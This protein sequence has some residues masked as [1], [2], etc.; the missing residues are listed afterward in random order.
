M[1]LSRKE[2][3]ESIKFPDATTAPGPSTRAGDFAEILVAD[4]LEFIEEY[5][6]PSRTTRYSNKIK[7][8]ESSKGNDVIALRLVDFPN[9]NLKD[10]L[11]IFEAK[12]K[13]TGRTATERLQDA[14]DGSV[15]D[16]L[17]LAE[18]L[19][20]MKQRFIDCG[21]MDEAKMIDRF[22]KEA[23]RPDSV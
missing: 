11:A 14:I 4:F 10:E 9:V 16:K 18:S 19:N 13:F 5:H 6:V 21:S 7:R 3:L 2:Y 8:N 1:G 12:A 20:A 22:Q 23:V 15:K 17:R